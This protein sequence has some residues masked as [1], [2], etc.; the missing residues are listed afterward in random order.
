MI[1]KLQCFSVFSILTVSL[2]TSAPAQKHAQ[3]QRVNPDMLHQP[4]GYTHVV[5]VR[6]GKTVYI[7]GQVPLDKQGNLI[8]AGDFS[9]QVRQAFEN[10]KTALGAAGADFSNVVNM[11]TYVTDLSQIDKYRAIRDEYMKSELPAATLVEVKSLFR[12]DVMIEMSAV[13]VTH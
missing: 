9:A 12:P 8:G 6:S 4:H 10:M 3:I 11:N 2:V 13:A 5:I 7:A 1:S